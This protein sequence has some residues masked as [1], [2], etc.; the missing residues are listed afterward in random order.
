[1]RTWFRSGLALALLAT[2]CAEPGDDGTD[3]G[4][5]P[6]AERGTARVKTRW[7]EQTMSYRVIDGRAIAEGDID[8]GPVARLQL[9]ANTAIDT[10]RRWPDGVVHYTFDPAIAA[11]DVRRTRVADAIAHYEAL[12]PVRFVEEPDDV[13]PDEAPNCTDYVYITSTTIPGVGGTSALGRVGGKQN[14]TLAA[15]AS[16]GTVIHEFGHALGLSHEQ[17]RPDRASYVTI[18]SE[19]IDTGDEADDADNE[20]D[21]NGQ[22]NVSASSEG[23]GA[24][25]FASVMHYSSTGGRDE[26]YLAAPCNGRQPMERKATAWCP[27]SICSDPGNDGVAEFISAQRTALSPGDV[28]SMW[29]M[30]A[31]GIGASEAGDRLGAAIAAGDFD[32]DGFVDVAVGAP[33]EDVG[34]VNAAGAVFVWKGSGEGFQPWLTITQGWLGAASEA[35]DELGA[36]LAVG[37][38]DADGYV[39]LVIGAPGEVNGGVSDIGAVFIARGSE[40][41]LVPAQTVTQATVGDLDEG[42]DRF[43]AA[44]AVGDFDGD[45]RD[46]VAIGAPGETLG[47]GPAA[48]RVFVLRGQ[49][50]GTVTAWDSVG[51]DEIAV[52]GNGGIAPPPVPLGVAAAGDAFGAALTAGRVDTDGR[53]DL[54]VGAP[55]DSD[56]ANCAGAVYLFRGAVGSLQGWRRLTRA[57]PTAFDRVGWSVAVVDRDGDGD[58]DLAAGAPYA[59][60]SGQT[61]SGLIQLWNT[62]GTSLSTSSLWSQ[63]PFAA[64]EPGDLFGATLASVARP[65]LFSPAQLYAAAPVEGTSGDLVE[66]GVV[67]RFTVTG[68]ALGHNALVRESPVGIEEDGDE[69]GRGLAVYGALEGT[70][71]FVGAPGENDDSGAVYVLGAIGNAA[72]THRQVLVQ[73]GAGSHTA[74]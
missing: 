55:C 72:P 66:T 7:G 17:N 28:N 11:N 73:H 18:N 71:I 25:D 19:C 14:L 38:L 70:Y 23:F 37:D 47:A 35:T 49:A 33:G 64:N 43:G 24:Y 5:A 42:N 20:I 62:S 69:F 13:C 65:V 31:E 39:D 27:E 48:G 57:A 9:Y 32:G 74:P 29:G 46:D 36:A 56:N 67:Q 51:Q 2:A 4:L 54:V 21:W 59:T 60:V 50:N 1:M 53:Y 26:D 6:V 34:A 44:L 8:L 61:S 41:G 16:V 22:Y 68:G 15:N 3:D 52:V 30:Y 40:A 58:G 10:T 63:S 45:S 12:T